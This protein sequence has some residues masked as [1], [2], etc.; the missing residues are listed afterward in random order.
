MGSSWLVVRG[1][2]SVGTQ[3][4]GGDYLANEAEAS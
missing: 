3:E 4:K 1:W 2:Y